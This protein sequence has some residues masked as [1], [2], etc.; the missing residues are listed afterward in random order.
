MKTDKIEGVAC[1]FKNNALYIVPYEIEGD[2]QFSSEFVYS[3]EGKMWSSHTQGRGIEMAG[4]GGGYV[5][6][7]PKELESLLLTTD[8]TLRYIA[9]DAILKHYLKIN[10][11]NGFNNDHEL[12]AM[13]NRK[14]STDVKFNILR[15]A[16]P[17]AT[18]TPLS[19][20]N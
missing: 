1:L 13:I 7:I 5:L 4:K 14:E 3:L 2:Y 9:I 15:T 20:T 18:P 19:E 10:V 16:R 12:L 17:E 8:H 6:D 11:E